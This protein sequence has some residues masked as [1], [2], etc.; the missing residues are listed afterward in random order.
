VLSPVSMAWPMASH[1]LREPVRTPDRSQ[2]AYNLAYR[3]WTLE[4]IA[5]GEFWETVRRGA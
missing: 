4:E 2:W 3:Q 1:N 5:S